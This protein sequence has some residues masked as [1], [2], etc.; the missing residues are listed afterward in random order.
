MLVELAADLLSRVPRKTAH[1][2]LSHQSH[3]STN[4]P[5]GERAG[6]NCWLPVLQEPGTGKASF[7]AVAGPWRRCGYVCTSGARSWEIRMSCIAET[8][9]VSTREPGSKTLSSCNVFLTPPLTKHDCQLIKR[10]I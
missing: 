8:C 6:G 1:M 10:N 9:C 3:T 4:S 7:T 2:E 5:G